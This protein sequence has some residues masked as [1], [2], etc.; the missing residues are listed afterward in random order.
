[1]SDSGT[2]P[3][4]PGHTDRAFEQ[5]LHTV[6]GA[7]LRMA[8][9][10]EHM[11]GRAGQALVQ[12]DGALARDVIEED[13]EVNRAEVEIDELCLRILAKRQP[14]AS[15]LRFVTLAMKMV[16]DLER[17]ADLAVNICERAVDLVDS[18]VVVH[19]EIPAMCSA[20]EN[21]V[22]QAIEA[23]VNRDVAKARAVID[24]DD[25]VDD[26]YH[27]IFEDLLGRMHA[28]PAQLHQWI[29]VQSVAKWLERMG[30]H[31]TNLAELVIF[32][33]EG[34]DVRHPRLHGGKPPS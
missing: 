31:S 14:M 7:L 13:Q 2:T 15:D 30:D 19:A 5:E 12:R 21:M 33:V 28:E 32:M 27:R 24:G 23:F 10:V 4:G 18:K 34:R 26:Y 6:R 25:V 22:H 1:M 29:H 16:T 11:I 20:V 9:H 8:G 3:A 17:I